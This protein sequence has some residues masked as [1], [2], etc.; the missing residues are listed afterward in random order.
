MGRRAREIPYAHEGC[1]NRCRRRFEAMQFIPVMT[2]LRVGFLVVH[3]AP[4]VLVSNGRQ[5]CDVLPVLG[6]E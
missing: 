4:T 3:V 1:R 6:F 5:D 2:K